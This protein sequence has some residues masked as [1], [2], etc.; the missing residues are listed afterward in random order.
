MSDFMN[1]H[2]AD[3]AAIGEVLVGID[4]TDE[5]LYVLDLAVRRGPHRARLELVHVH[6]HPS[7]L[8]GSIP[9]AAEYDESQR[10]L[11]RTLTGLAGAH[12]QGLPG[13]LAAHRASRCP[14]ETL[15]AAADELDADL[16]V[17]GHRHHGGLGDLLLGSVASHVV[18]HARR[19]VLVATRNVAEWRSPRL[20]EIAS[21][22]G[23]SDIGDPSADQ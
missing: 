17:V 22:R 21:P 6:P 7:M 23:V 4:D 1:F 16:I 2:D 13:R 18:H 12:L 10:Q 3:V 9:A 19:P 14:A 5:S 8:G 15:L 11:E 20:V